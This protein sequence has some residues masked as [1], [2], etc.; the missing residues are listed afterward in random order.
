MKYRIRITVATLAILLLAAIPLQISTPQL[1]AQQAVQTETP[2]RTLNVSGTSKISAQPDVAV[3]TVGVET[4]A[5]TASEALSQN[6]DKMSSVVNALT[7][8]GVAA[9][10][11]Q[12]QVVQLQPIYQ[13]PQPGT[14][15]PMTTTLPTL[16]GYTATNLVQ[17]RVRELDN[18]G[19]TLDAV[20]QAGGNRIEDI[21]F[22]LS[23]P[24]AVL[25]QARQAAWNDAQHKAQQLVGLADVQLGDVLSITESSPGPVP[26]IE[27]AA[28]ASAA[29]VPIQPGTLT[30][31]VDLQVTWLL[32]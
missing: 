29:A 11:V 7:K 28:I 31:E 13:Q 9:A 2:Q 21:S 12:T 20:V 1:A 18:L 14:T 15:T 19:S 6:S 23:D 8:A 24:S 16:I 25:D 4:E 32:Q 5:S 27:R 3:V 26:V 17:V 10:D 22:E 30:V